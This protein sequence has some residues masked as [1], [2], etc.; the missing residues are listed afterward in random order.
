M[1]S[2][3]PL[4][5]IIS[6]AYNRRNNVL[7]LMNVLRQQ[8]YKNFE[9]ILIDNNSCDGTADAVEENFPKVKIIRCP[10]NFGNVSYNFGFVNA[11]GKYFFMIDDD[12]LPESCDLISQVVDHFE[13]NPRL[14]VVACT[15][16][17]RDTGYIA[18]DSPQFAPIGDTARGFQAAAYNGTGVGLR[19]AAVHEVGYYPFHFFLSWSELHLCTRLIE[20]GWEIRYFPSLEVWHSRPSGSSNRPVTYYGLRNYLWYVW[21]FYPWPH[22]FGETLHVLGS[23]FRLTLTGRMSKKTFLKAL[24][25]GFFGW[26]RNSSERQPISSDTLAYLRHVRQYSNNQGVAPKHRSF[27]ANE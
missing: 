1:N 16:R 10:Q 14:A 21:S 12:G 23:R 15:I 27:S 5:S 4:V 6:V 8:N 9:V 18:Y 11:K 25:D 19:A 20:A 13:A 7:E 17:M 22:I 26:P 2:S 3:S 24:M